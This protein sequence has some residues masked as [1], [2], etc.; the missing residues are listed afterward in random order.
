MKYVLNVGGGAGRHLPN[1]YDGWE[2]HLL[3]ID[4]SVNPDICCDTRQMTDVVK[5]Q[6]YDAVYCSHNLEHYYKHEVQTIL[7]NFK[8]AL[9]LG[10][11]IEIHVPNLKNLVDTIKMSNLDIDDVWYRLEG[12]IPVSFHD[13][14]YG[15][16]HAMSNGNIYYAHKCGFTAI[17][18]NKEL[19][20][21][22]FKD[23]IIQENGPNLAAFGKV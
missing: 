14:L 4:S 2:Q 8:F 15:W 1:H 23:I 6:Y 12:G 5:S 19:T 3:D 9:K 16:N 20:S 10:G 22:G 7:N 17:S 13:V 21:A 18:L 11:T